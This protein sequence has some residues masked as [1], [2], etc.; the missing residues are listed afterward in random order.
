MRLPFN[1]AT[2][3]KSVSQCKVTSKEDF[4]APCKHMLSP[5]SQMAIMLKCNVS[6]RFN[7]DH[8]ISKGGMFCDFNEC[9]SI[10]A[11]L[12]VFISLFLESVFQLDISHSDLKARR[13]RFSSTGPFLC[14]VCMISSWVCGFSLCTPTSSHTPKHASPV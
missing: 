13:P 10:K 11:H 1:Y 7:L 5:K 14:G 2:N 9:V 4:W 12:P 8:W 6:S 3:K